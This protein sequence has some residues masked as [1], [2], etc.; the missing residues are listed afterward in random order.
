MVSDPDAFDLCEV[1]EVEAKT[2]Y[3]VRVGAD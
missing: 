2:E 3:S 1:G